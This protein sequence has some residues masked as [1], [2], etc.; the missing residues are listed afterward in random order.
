M[1]L[2]IS[3]IPK[4]QTEILK[5]EDRQ[6]HGQKSKEKHSACNSSLKA[7]ESRTLQKLG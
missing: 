6:D 2:K 3:K 7:L 5:T 1:W 4:R